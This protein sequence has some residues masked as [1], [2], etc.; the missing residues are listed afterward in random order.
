[1]S[2]VRRTAR[3]LGYLGFC[4][5]AA[6]VLGTKAWAQGWSR[7]FGTVTNDWVRGLA[8]DE[9]SGDVFVGGTTDGHFPSGQGLPEKSPWVAKYDR[10]GNQVWLRQYLTGVYSYAAE[11]L[12]DGQGGVYLAGQTDYPSFLPPEG[13]LKR[14]DAAGNTVWE[15]KFI[16]ASQYYVDVYAAASNRQGSV[17]L[18]GWSS[19]HLVGQAASDDTAW[20]AKVDSAGNL[21]WVQQF[22]DPLAQ[23]IVFG[24]A[25]DSSGRVFVGLQST[26]YGGPSRV[27]LLHLDA[28]GALVW[29]RELSGPGAQ[30][31][32][33]SMTL[34]GSGDVYLAGYFDTQPGTYNYVPWIAHF[35][36]AGNQ[37]WT[38]TVP[39]AGGTV[40]ATTAPDG[41]GGV[42]VGGTTTE[43]LTG[44]PNGVLDAWIG[45]FDQWGNLVDVRQFGAGGSSS[46]NAIARDRLGGVYMAGGTNDAL[47]G[48]N[49][50]FIDVWVGSFPNPHMSAY[51][52]PAQA[53]STGRPARL[54]VFGSDQATVDPLVLGV[55]CLPPS[56]FG[57]LLV[58][59]TTGFVPFAGGSQGHLCLGGGI[60]RMN[61]P[62]EVLQSSPFGR[63]ERSIDKQSIPQPG[64]PVAIQSGQTWH[65]QAW[66]RDQNPGS[67]SNFS[68]AVSIQFH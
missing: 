50:G 49:Q 24:A 32:L 59:Q 21:L 6:Q 52:D 13:W 37:S 58:S 46:L 28:A 55:T 66:Y 16:S 35:D 36:A 30:G 11:V 2:P 27:F 33:A 31:R 22:G 34:G 10:L 42:Y 44:M 15:Q 56:T 43:S 1:M 3:S 62:G 54:Q 25:I 40:L 57:Y 20:I 51:C 41:L 23:D 14:I 29:R 47:F 64:G 9:C 45:Q 63:F 4:L 39:S 18:G 5:L 61:G 68:D 60:G 26:L 38:R 48:V 67:T 53:N 65:F 19:G 12:S 8:V 17:V 7:Q